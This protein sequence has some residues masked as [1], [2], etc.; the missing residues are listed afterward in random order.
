ME[1]SFLKKNYIISRMNKKYKKL[2]GR[3]IVIIRRP[4]IGRNMYVYICVKLGS[5]RCCILIRYES[6]VLH[7]ALDISKS[8]LISNY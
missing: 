2:Y 4:T 5:E 3:V 7:S 1:S 8:K 6:N